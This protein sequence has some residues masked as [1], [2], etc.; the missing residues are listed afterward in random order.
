[1][2]RETS[3]YFCSIVALSAVISLGVAGNYQYKFSEQ[4]YP[5]TAVEFLMKENVPGNTFTH[6]GFGDYLIYAA[7]PQHRVFIDGR[8]DMYG[9]D[10]LRE[11]LNLA[12][13]LPGWKDIIDKYA[14]NS[15]LFDTHSALASVLAEDRNWHLIYSDPLASIFLRKDGENQHLIDKYPH[16]ALALDENKTFSS[17]PQ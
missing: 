15:I 14:F 17:D 7:W 4:S 11:Y 5:V 1:M 8:T 10:R 9:A 12:H 3:G 2:E 16:V 13:A 6:D